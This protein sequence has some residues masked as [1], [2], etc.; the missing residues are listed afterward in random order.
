[1]GKHKSTMKK[2][3]I[4]NGTTYLYD[5]VKGQY[6]IRWCYAG[7]TYSRPREI[8]KCKRTIK[9]QD[10]IIAKYIKENTK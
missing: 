5:I 10:K 4:L 3:F 2:F 9:F 8:G 1:M 7:G 6:R